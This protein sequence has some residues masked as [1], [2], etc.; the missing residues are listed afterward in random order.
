M[1]KLSVLLALLLLAPALSGCSEESTGGIGEQM[2]GWTP[3]FED[4]FENPGSSLGSVASPFYQ[5]EV[6]GSSGVSS[7]S[8]STGNAAR[9]DGFTSYIGYSGSVLPPEE[10]TIRFE[11]R[12]PSG[13]M[14]S[15][16]SLQP[17]WLAYNGN[18]PPYCGFILDTVGWNGAFP[19]GFSL[20]LVFQEGN[21]DY[22]ALSYGTWSGSDWSYA[23]GEVSPEIWLDGQFHEIVI[24]WSASR[25]SLGIW[26]D[27]QKA[28]SAAWNTAKDP[29]EGFFLGHN[30][31]HFA[32]MGYWPYGPHSLMGDY[33]NL[34]IYDQAVQ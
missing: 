11:W 3:V 17:D 16:T 23:T 18:P 20:L 32:D 9:L 19:G 10:G 6:P 25:E 30:P 21:Q 33:G 29:K 15:Y 13:L 1:K 26:V 4:D 31:W 24:S 34:R 14:D 2:A 5:Q 8:G 12:A 27:G 28:A 7:T 22:S